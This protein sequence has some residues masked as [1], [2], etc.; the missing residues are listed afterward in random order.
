MILLYLQ[1]KSSFKDILVFLA[2]KG[3]FNSSA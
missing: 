2:L 1:I 3:Q